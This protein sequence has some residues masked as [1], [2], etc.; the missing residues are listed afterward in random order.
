MPDTYNYPAEI[1]RDEDDRYVV[2]FPDRGRDELAL[3]GSSGSV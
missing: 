2:A 1:A 3:C